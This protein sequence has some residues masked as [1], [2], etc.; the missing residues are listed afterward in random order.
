V[1]SAVS[2]NET[3]REQIPRRLKFITPKH[4]M[5]AARI[6]RVKPATPRERER[7]STPQ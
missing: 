3:S 1:M 5:S 7:K 4:C 6:S 2:R